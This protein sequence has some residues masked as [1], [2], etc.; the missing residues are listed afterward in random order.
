VA[1][2]QQQHHLCQPDHS[3][4]V[5]IGFL[6]NRSHGISFAYTAK[7]WNL[8][9]GRPSLVRYSPGCQYVLDLAFGMTLR[10]IQRYLGLGWDLIKPI[11]PSLSR[12]SVLLRAPFPFPIRLFIGLERLL[13]SGIVAEISQEAFEA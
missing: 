10:D 3:T 6:V 2:Q 11:W 5:H 7:S 4:I 8:P 12:L 1:I 9:R 13:L